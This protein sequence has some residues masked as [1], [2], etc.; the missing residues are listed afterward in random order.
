MAGNRS[1]PKPRVVG[2]PTRISIS[3]LIII[4][5]TGLLGCCLGDI[6]VWDEEDN[7]LMSVDSTFIEFRRNQIFN[8]AI[9]LKSVT[10]PSMNGCDKLPRPPNIVSLSDTRPSWIL[11]MDNSHDCEAHEKII[12]V[13]NAGYEGLILISGSSGLTDADM[14]DINPAFKS[15]FKINVSLVRHIDGLNLKQFSVKTRESTRY[16]LTIRGK[17]D[18][19]TTTTTTTTPKPPIVEQPPTEKPPLEKSEE[20]KQEKPDVNK[21]TPSH[22]PFFFPIFP[23]SSN[24][25][26]IAL[27]FLL[28]PGLYFL[29]QWRLKDVMVLCMMIGVVLIVFA[30][31]Q[32]NNMDQSLN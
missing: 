26:Y 2:I 25:I 12:N 17:V 19:P 24:L 18:T 15:K 5:V 6:I 4:V 30:L 10:D 7:Y 32:Q 21:K 3:P 27:L 9:Y 11:M 20:P 23:N 14:L 28:P 31:S 1:L 16:T 29:S 8:D 13:Q 22:S